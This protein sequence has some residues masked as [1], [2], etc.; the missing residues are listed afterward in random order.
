MDQ[1][2]FEDLERESIL[3]SLPGKTAYIDECGNFG[4][5]F[6]SVGVST[7][8]ILCAVVAEDSDL[9][10]LHAEVS[11]VKANNG[12]PKN[13]EL[14]S[15]SIGNNFRRRSKIVSDLLPIKFRVILF[16]ADKQAFVKGRPLTEYRQSFIKYLHQRLYSI[17]YAAYPKL[18]IIEDQIG[19]SEFQSSFKEY[20]KE[21]RPQNLFN[22]YD[23]DYTDSKDEL[24]VQLADFIGGT[25]GKALT[26]PDSPDYLEILKGKILC[27]V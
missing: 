19:S 7:K 26:E 18:R 4:F 10:K 6:S 16:V 2:S 22:E 13:T 9:P 24:F 23:F 20:V 27:I 15:S 14:K 1:I 8:Y 21:H 3:A 5:D 17:L 25:I 12:F 11:Q